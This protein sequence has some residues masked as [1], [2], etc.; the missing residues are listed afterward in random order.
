MIKIN[1]AVIVEDSIPMQSLIKMVLQ[2]FGAEQ[3]IVLNNG[4]EAISCPEMSKA[5]IVIMDWNMAV[6]DGLEC[7]RKI[8]SGIDGVDKNLP[9]ILLTGNCGKPNEAY[10]AGVNGYIEKPFSL[11]SLHDVVYYTLESIVAT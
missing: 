7:T 8:R 4:A 11:K 3:I 10:E 6:M 9:I 2:S 1:C 5:D